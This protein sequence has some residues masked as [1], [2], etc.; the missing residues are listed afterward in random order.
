MSRK[1]Y[2]AMAKILGDHTASDSLV[3]DFIDFLAKDNPRFD[4]LKFFE[5]VRK[6]N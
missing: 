2:V 6:V 3:V 5:A 4:R 1:D